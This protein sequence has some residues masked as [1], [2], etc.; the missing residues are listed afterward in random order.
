MKTRPLSRVTPASQGVASSALLT[1]V[2]RLAAECDSL[3][4]LMILRHG[5]VIAEGWWDPYRPG[6]PHVLFSLSKSFTSTAAGLAISEGLFSLDDPVTRFF[7]DDLPAEVNG[8]LAAM[9]VRHLL[10][11]ST[12][13][14]TDTL[15]ALIRRESTHWVREFLAC[16]VT[17]PPG[18]LFLYNSGATYMVS[19]IVQQVTGQTLVD[20]L[21]PRLFGPLGIPRPAWDT[22]PRGINTG[23]WGLHLA[24]EDIARFG[25]LYLQNGLWEGERLLPAGWVAEATRAHISNGTDPASDWCQGYGFQFWRCQHGAYRGD[26]AFGQYCVVL[27]R[28][29]VVVALTAGLGDMQAP[30]NL[31]WEHLLPALAGEPLPPD[32]ETDER[33][34][35]RLA[36]L[37]VPAPAGAATASTASALTGRIFGLDA[38]ADGLQSLSF[39]FR[40]GTLGL[41]A[42]WGRSTLRFG[43]GGDWL[44]QRVALDANGPQ[45]LGASGAWRDDST[46]ELALCWHHTPFVRRWTCRFEPGQ[47]TIARRLNLSMFEPLEQPT[48]VG[49]SAV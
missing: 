42:D 39:D 43:A 8:H 24:T 29:Q 31:L 26:G 47:V 41:R 49:R 3:H 28:Q 37:R 32:P 48:L 45:A 9:K 34:R 36:T 23:G 46:F 2:E 13:H 11:M 16:P 14:E 38:N 17:V 35:A 44:R 10:S 15:G 25:Q 20:Y 30:L 22:C 7:P 33:L 12:G 6:E 4:S 1:L 21:T 27:P 5:R 40:A 19:A 18:S